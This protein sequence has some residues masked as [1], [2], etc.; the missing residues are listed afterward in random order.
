MIANKGVWAT[1]LG[2][3]DF[4]YEL[5]V[6][7]LDICMKSREHT[8]GLL[9]VQELLKQLPNVTEYFIDTNF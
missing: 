6:Q 5:S 2:V 3:G 1:V 4:Y 9:S 8:G 7:I